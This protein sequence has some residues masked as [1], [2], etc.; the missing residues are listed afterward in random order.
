MKRKYLE[1]TE[2]IQA[3]CTTVLKAILENAYCDA[4]NA[5]K[6]RWQRCI[7]AEG[8]YFESFN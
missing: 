1:A 2:G 5:W 3:A 8:A 7:D 4:F 6:S